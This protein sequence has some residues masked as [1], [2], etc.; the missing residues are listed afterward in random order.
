MAFFMRM[1]PADIILIVGLTVAAFTWLGF[2]HAGR[3][4][5]SMVEIYNAEGLFMVVPLEKDAEIRVPGPLGES[6]VVV[7]DGR[8]H[9]HSSPCP[10]QICVEMGE[11]RHSGENVVCIPNRVSIR[12]RGQAADIDAVVY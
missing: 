7:R 1:K 11:I 9:M 3:E 10:H 6:L 2:L 12:I 5:G 8:V 4:A